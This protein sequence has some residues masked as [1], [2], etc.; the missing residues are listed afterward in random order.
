MFDSLLAIVK[1][2]LP[3]R[4]LPTSVY[5]ARLVSVV[6]LGMVAVWFVVFIFGGTHLG[7][8]MGL[9]QIAIPP[10]VSKADLADMRLSLVGNMVGLYEEQP[11][12]D[13]AFLV[14]AFD[15]DGEFTYFDKAER[16]KLEAWFMP[17]YFRYPRAI[18]D[19]LG[20]NRDNY[21][22]LLTNKKD[23]ISVAIKKV[24]QDRLK[25][26]IRGFDS[27]RSIMCPVIHPKTNRTFAA[28]IV[29]WKAPKTDAEF[30]QDTVGLVRQATLPISN[31]ILG[32]KNL[33]LRD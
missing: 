24:N 29:F 19:I 18:E 26:V 4:N 33:A 6:A 11:A 7:A 32:Q 5:L 25:A 10:Q 15:K 1:D 3:D 8:K 17:G 21:Q 13:A 23:C 20:L 14:T 22:P 28:L 31:N 9:N 30:I 2:M 12:I 16:F 27:D